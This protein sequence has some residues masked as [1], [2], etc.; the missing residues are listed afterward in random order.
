MVNAF[1]CDN[2][3]LIGIFNPIINSFLTSYSNLK[4]E[5]ETSVCSGVLLIVVI[6]FFII[7]LL[8]NKWK[9]SEPGNLNEL[10]EVESFSQIKDF[11]PKMIEAGKKAISYTKNNFGIDL[12]FSINSIL[13]LK[14][15]FYKLKNLNMQGRIAKEQRKEIITLFGAYLGEIARTTWGGEWIFEHDEINNSKKIYL[16]S[17]F[18]R[19]NPFEPVLSALR[20]GDI[21][22]MIVFMEILRTQLDFYL[23]SEEE[24]NNSL[25]DQD[26][27]GVQD[28]PYE[29]FS[30]YIFGWAGNYFSFSDLSSLSENLQDLNFPFN[31]HSQAVLDEIRYLE[32]S[33]RVRVVINKNKE[34]FILDLAPYI[35]EKDFQFL[36]R[37]TLGKLILSGYSKRDVVN[38]ML[39]SGFS[40]KDKNIA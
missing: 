3:I 25:Y 23:P 32:P 18:K 39:V 31:H 2:F 30:R 10:A 19:I 7:G 15:V 22:V 27:D 35:F 20:T 21:G 29:V 1:L 5:A 38:M 14:S 4:T 17:K 33:E 9:L 34:E 40:F 12:D 6:V 37:K 36:T 26:I 8:V 16:L 24:L 13:N 11:S 28:F